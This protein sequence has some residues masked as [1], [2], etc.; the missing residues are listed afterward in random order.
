MPKSFTPPPPM[1]WDSWKNVGNPLHHT[2]DFLTIH[3][4]VFSGQS[5][6]HHDTVQIISGLIL[7]HLMLFRG[8]LPL[9]V[10]GKFVSLFVCIGKN[11]CFIERVESLHGSIQNTT[12][13][14]F[15]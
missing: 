9:D 13:Q 11:I 6:M 12:A 15:A 1:V 2:D 8:I 7:E 5:A 10:C 3:C 4:P 14:C